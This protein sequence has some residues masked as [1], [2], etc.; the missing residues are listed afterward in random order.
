MP[1]AFRTIGAYQARAGQHN[2]GLAQTGAELTF[3][4]AV[5][6]ANARRADPLRPA[7]A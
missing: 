1:F 3:A 6:V 7:R 4:R 5:A 2:R